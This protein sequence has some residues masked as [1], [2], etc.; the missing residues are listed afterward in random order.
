[1]LKQAAGGGPPISTFQPWW[2][3]LGRR[4]LRLM[5]EKAHVSV[6]ITLRDGTIQQI[7]EDRSYLPANIPT[8]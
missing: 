6:V 4:V 8:E 2:L 3:N 5:L 7:R 1:M